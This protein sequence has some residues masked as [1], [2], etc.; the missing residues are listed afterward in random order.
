MR[1]MKNLCAAVALGTALFCASTSHATPVSFVTVGT[2]I[3]GDASGTSVYSDIANGVNIAFTSSIGN[4]VDV[5]PA[6][7]VSFG[8]FDSSATTAPNFVAVNA[9]FYL[10]IFQT[11]PAPISANPP[12]TQFPP[13]IP[14]GVLEFVGSLSGTLRVSNSQAFVDFGP[15]ASGTILGAG[16]ITTLYSIIS[17]DGGTPGRVAISA[18]QANNGLTTIAG[19]VNAVVPEPSSLV[20]LGLGAPV[21]LVYR[22]RR[23]RVAA[24]A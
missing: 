4:D 7:Q 24:A 21:L 2:F 12:S 9:T 17:A 20:L 19:L 13:P 14:P 11:I 18:P 5:P 3:S 16:G 10:N 8:Q 23:N 1:I 22:A 6:S 15:G